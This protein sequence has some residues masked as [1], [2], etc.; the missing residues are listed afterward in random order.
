MTQ[1]R[2]TGKKRAALKKPAWF[3]LLTACQS[4]VIDSSM[5]DAVGWRSGLD[6]E[7]I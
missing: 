3:L 7:L 2:V 5:T 4:K 1:L 6:K